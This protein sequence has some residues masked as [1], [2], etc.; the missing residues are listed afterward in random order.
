MVRSRS[1]LLA[2]FLL[3]LKYCMS[4]K[5]K[6]MCEPSGPSGRCCSMKW[7]RSILLPLD[8]LLVHRRFTHNIQFARQYP[9]VHLGEERHFE[10]IGVLHNTPQ[11]LWP[12]LEPRPLNLDS[13]A[14][15]MIR[16]HHC[17]HVRLEYCTV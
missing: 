2:Q 3:Y 10:N 4:V 11:Y 6:S 13:I 12:V 15:T 16:S 1:F 8:R 14:L 17:G 9:F 5:V 7:L